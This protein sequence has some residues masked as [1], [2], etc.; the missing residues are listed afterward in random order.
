MT[1]KSPSMAKTSPLLPAISINTVAMQ[2]KLANAALI[3]SGQASSL[4]NG[5]GMLPLGMPTATPVPPSARL[6]L[7]DGVSTLGP[8]RLSRE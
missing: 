1:S 2:Q 4:H 3:P 7:A 5:D 8:A 6:M